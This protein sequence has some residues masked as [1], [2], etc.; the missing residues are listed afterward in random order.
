MKDDVTQQILTAAGELFA[1]HGYRET[2]VRDIC[3]RAK[4]NVS[5]VNYYFGDKERLYVQAVKNAR[6]QMERRVPLPEWDAAT[7][8]E[9]KLRQ[10]VETMI[11]RMLISEGSSWQT[12]LLTREIM[13]P[14]RACEEMVQESFLPFFQLLLGIVRELSAANWPDHKIEKI[15]MSIISQIV[16]YRA[17]DRIVEL[18]IGSN[19]LQQHYRPHDLVNHITEFTLAALHA[20]RQADQPSFDRTASSSPN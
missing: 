11:R 7:P 17:Q 8:P 13:E 10:F 12:R 5:A 4:V 1:E 6:L 19:Q 20:M 15:G 2:T 3:K 16:H 9:Q 14:T 18:L